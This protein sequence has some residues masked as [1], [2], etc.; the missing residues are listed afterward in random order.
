MRL[1]QRAGH[2][3]R[4]KHTQ[5]AM[6]DPSAPTLEV[7]LSKVYGDSR[8]VKGMSDDLEGWYKVGDFKVPLPKFA[9]V[10][11]LSGPFALVASWVDGARADM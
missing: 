8:D 6:G 11:S 2:L 3:L 9:E 7:H 1:P 10:S 5:D 4:E